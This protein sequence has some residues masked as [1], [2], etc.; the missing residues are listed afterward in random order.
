MGKA[1]SF[2]IK[3]LKNEEVN[4]PKNKNCVVKDLEK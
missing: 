3:F 2:Q 4:M 1:V